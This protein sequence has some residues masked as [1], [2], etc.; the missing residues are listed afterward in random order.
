MAYDDAGRKVSET[1]PLG[2]VTKFVY[3]KV[4]RL[5]ETILPDLTLNDDTDNARSK[6]EY[7]TDGLVKAQIDARGNRTEFRYDELGR[8]IAVIA[9]DTTPNDLS[10]NPTSRRHRC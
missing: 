5:K 9:A 10:D 2:R 8:Q 3:D 4:G 6:S 1:D 7:Y